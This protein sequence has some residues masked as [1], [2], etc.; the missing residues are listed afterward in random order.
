MERKLHFLV[1]AGNT[2]ER[3]DEVR[4]WGNIF[5]GKT[6]LDAA[7]A[8]LDLGDVTLL[9][10]NQIH[11]KEFDGYYGRKGM[12]GIETFHTHSEL[13]DLLEERLTGR[14]AGPVD[15]VLM[16]AAVSDYRPV[17]A[18]RMVRR[19]GQ[20]A[21]FRTP[22]GDEL[23]AGAGQE[24]WVVENVQAAKVKSTHGTIAIL[25]ETTEKL[26][27]LFRTRWHFKGLLVK[28]KLEAGIS[29]EELVRVASASRLA[30]GA[31]FIVANTLEMVQGH[32]SDP[33]ARPGAYVIG[34]GLCERI[35]RGNLAERLRDLAQSQL[36]R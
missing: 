1:T 16:S 26:V 23:A 9:T 13:R 25:G 30:S 7:M 15:A 8:L 35:D 33:A 11:A 24:V 36:K 19:A 14:D 5:T 17:G 18:F 27:D 31:D 3:I 12:L 10:S 29:E 6:G 4:D 2:R 21:T 28:F 22:E 32:S 34:E 20:G